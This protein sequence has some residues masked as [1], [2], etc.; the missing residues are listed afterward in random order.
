MRPR[1]HGETPIFS[2]AI[3]QMDEYGDHRIILVRKVVI[4]LKDA[5][6]F[7]VWRKLDGGKRVYLM[8]WKR[9]SD[10]FRFDVGLGMVQTYVRR[11]HG[12]SHNVQKV[13][14]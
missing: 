12:F 10:F 9:S 7:N 4:V 5:Y 3:I 6:L 2:I 1:K 8:G 13:L 14:V 11:P